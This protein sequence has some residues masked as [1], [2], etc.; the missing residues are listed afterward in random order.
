[1]LSYGHTQNR[2]SA[3]FL[4]RDNGNERKTEVQYPPP[5]THHTMQNEVQGKRGLK[6]ARK[7]VFKQG[8]K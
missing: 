1:L 6:M 7:G 3:Q 2:I 4:A 8:K 5:P